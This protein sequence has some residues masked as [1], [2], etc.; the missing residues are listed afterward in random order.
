MEKWGFF[1]FE[2]SAAEIF[3]SQILKKNSKKNNQIFPRIHLTYVKLHRHLEVECMISNM[4]HDE[5]ASY[6]G[7]ASLQKF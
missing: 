5:A 1:S 4:T 6:S 2:A 3:F 7:D